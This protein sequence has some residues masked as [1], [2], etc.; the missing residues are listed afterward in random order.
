MKGMA[1][2]QRVAVLVLSLCLGVEGGWVGQGIE[3]SVHR[4]LSM[5]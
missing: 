3:R 5:W 1:A 2:G 4:P